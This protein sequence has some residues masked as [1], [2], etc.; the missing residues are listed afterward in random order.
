MTQAALLV[1][2]GRI[3]MG[4]DLG[5]GADTLV[6]SHARALSTH[7]DFELAAA[8]DPDPSARQRFMAHYARPAFAT[9]QEACASARYDLAVIASPTSMH[10]EDVHAV[11]GAPGLY[12]VLCEKPLAQSCD[13]A[14]QVLAACERHGVRL[15]VNYIRRSEPG[16]IEV[17]RR[18]DTGE[19]EGPTKGVAWYTKGLLHNGSH[20][21][22]LLE[23]WLGSVTGWR[24]LERVR[25]LADGDAELDVRVEFVGGQVTF[26]AAREEDYAHYAVDLLAR[27]GRLRYEQGG[28]SISWTPRADAPR[29]AGTRDLATTD[30]RIVGDFDRYQWHVFDALSLACSGRDAEICTGAEALL[31]INH[32]TQMLERDF[33]HV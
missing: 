19:F 21:L 6:L 2:L 7:P 10:T 4:Y 5:S 8:V 12:A 28:A 18:F 23:R 30:E 9:I 3:G 17:A 13:L 14:R 24:V 29:G 33:P 1:G 25:S 31:T 26:L 15:F 32:I 16:A 22:N 27:N 11:L 20:L